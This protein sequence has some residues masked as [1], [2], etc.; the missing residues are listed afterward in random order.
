MADEEMVRTFNLGVG[1]TAVVPASLVEPALAAVPDA[2]RIGRV[3]EAG[4][5]PM[6]R[7]A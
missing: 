6:V 5:G 7:F 1:M 2:C 3:I 4:D